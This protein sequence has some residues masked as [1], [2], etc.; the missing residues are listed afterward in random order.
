MALL[1]DPSKD[2]SASGAVIITPLASRCSCCQRLQSRIS[3]NKSSLFR[4]LHFHN[5]VHFRIT[6]INNRNTFRDFTSPSMNCEIQRVGHVSPVQKHCPEVE[7]PGWQTE[8]PIWYGGVDGIYW[9]KTRGPK[10]NLLHEGFELLGRLSW[11]AIGVHMEK[12]L[13]GSRKW[14][15]APSADRSGVIELQRS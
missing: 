15:T 14:T 6:L 9:V 5:Y 4:E 8:E 2:T 7:S 12:G 1:F 11:G 3:I 13:S 10:A